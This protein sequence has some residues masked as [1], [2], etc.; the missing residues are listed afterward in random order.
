M[1]LGDSLGAALTNDIGSAVTDVAHVEV[2]TEQRSRGG[3]RPHALQPSAGVGIGVDLAVRALHRPEQTLSQVRGGSPLLI[4]PPLEETRD[5]RI[6]GHGAGHFTRLGT[7]HPVRDDEQRAHRWDSM[8]DAVGSRAGW[9]PQRTEQERKFVL[10]GSIPRAAASN[11]SK[12]GAGR[13]RRRGGW[14]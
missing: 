8:L 12:R 10:L 11:S 4:P 5:D 9:N 14:N 1:V 2:I 7:T 6:R 3:R 13:R